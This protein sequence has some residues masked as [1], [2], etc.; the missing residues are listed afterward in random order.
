MGLFKDLRDLS[1]AGKEIR[2]Q[3]YGDTSSWAMLK[4]GV[5]QAKDEVSQLAADQAKTQNR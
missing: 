5:A 1:K 2:K 4:Q 3:E